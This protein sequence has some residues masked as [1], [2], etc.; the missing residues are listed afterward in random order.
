L[1]LRFILDEL[2]APRP[3]QLLIAAGVGKLSRNDLLAKRYLCAAGVAAVWIDA[4]GHVVVLDVA[5]LDVEA[6]HTVYCYPRGAHFVLA[7]RLQ[8]W[9]AEQ[10]NDR[11]G[12]RLRPSSRSL[13]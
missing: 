11:R 7:Y 5:K 1:F 12:S 6:D 9:M 3:N 8:L 2:D 13:P 4:D 10:P